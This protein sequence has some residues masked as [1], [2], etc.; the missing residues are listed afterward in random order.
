MSKSTKSYTENSESKAAERRKVPS[1]IIDAIA[2]A[3]ALYGVPVILPALYYMHISDNGKRKYTGHNPLWL[4]AE[5]T[6]TRGKNG[7]AEYT[8]EYECYARYCRR[9]RL[10]HRETLKRLAGA[11]LVRAVEPD[12]E[13]NAYDLTQF[14]D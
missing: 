10:S 3:A 9:V 7:L 11:E 1:H 8:S 5:G 13:I 2:P 14:G 12:I 4:K 6:E